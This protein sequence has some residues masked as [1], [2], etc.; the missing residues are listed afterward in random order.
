MDEASVPF[1]SF[2]Y[3]SSGG[4]TSFLFSP[5]HMFC[6]PL[7]QPLIASLMPRVN[8]IGCLSPLARLVNKHRCRKSEKLRCRE[9]LWGV[10]KGQGNYDA[11]LRVIMIPADMNAPIRQF[12]YCRLYV[13]SNTVDLANPTERTLTNRQAPSQ[14]ISNPVNTIFPAGTVCC[15]KSNKPWSP[16]TQKNC[17]LK[18]GEKELRRVQHEGH[19]AASSFSK[20]PHHL[21]W[22]CPSPLILH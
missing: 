17:L 13:I 21:Q 20:H 18:K 22:F 4:M 9:G 14:K 3:A 11:F 2:P 8:Q 5:E 6:R 16:V 15:F 19:S 10:I 1:P 7:S 12:F